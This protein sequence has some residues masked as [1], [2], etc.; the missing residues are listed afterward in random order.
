MSDPRVA[1][2]VGL[3]LECPGCKRDIR[4]FVSMYG[5]AANG[6]NKGSSVCRCGRAVIGGY[7]STGLAYG[8]ERDILT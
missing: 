2:V 6:G 3:I 7:T 8:R 1:E 4:V 5:C